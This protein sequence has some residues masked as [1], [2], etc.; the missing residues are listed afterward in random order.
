MVVTA[1]RCVSV[2]GGKKHLCSHELQGLL[3]P[4]WSVDV[5]YWWRHWSVGGAPPQCFHTVDHPVKLPRFMRIVY[6]NIARVLCG[7]ATLFSVL[8]LCIRCFI[9]QLQI[10]VSL[11][12]YSTHRHSHNMSKY[13]N[14]RR[15][16]DNQRWLM[17]V[18]CSWLQSQSYRPPILAPWNCDISVQCFSSLFKIK[19]GKLWAVQWNAKVKVKP[20]LVLILLDAEFTPGS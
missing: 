14:V 2:F 15:F 8:G 11:I 9:T 1:I 5:F 10:D 16:P 13:P 4:S 7:L 17:R 18:H 12:D 6:Q 19:L 3:A 20:S